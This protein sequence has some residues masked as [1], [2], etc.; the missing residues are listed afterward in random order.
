MERRRPTRPA[1]EGIVGDV[2]PAIDDNRARVLDASPATARA[3]D[4]RIVSFPARWQRVLV[5]E[6]RIGK[7][8]IE[9]DAVLGRCIPE[10]RD[11]IGPDGAVEQMRP[12][13]IADG[14][15][16]QDGDRF[17]MRIPRLED[18]ITLGPAKT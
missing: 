15:R 3:V 6:D 5:R 17:P 4:A 11:A 10:S 14:G 8:L 9:R 2:D 18:G 16:I 1:I 7:A 12:L 13:A